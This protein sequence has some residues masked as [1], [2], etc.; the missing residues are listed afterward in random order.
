MFPQLPNSDISDK[1]RIKIRYG[2]QVASRPNKGKPT[3]T[4]LIF[5]RIQTNQ[6]FHSS[7]WKSS[8]WIAS[9]NFLNIFEP[10][11]ENTFQLPISGDP[12][13]YRGQQ[14][15]ILESKP[16]RR[17]PKLI[18]ASLDRLNVP[19][20]SLRRQFNYIRTAEGLRNAARRNHN[21]HW[22]LRSRNWL[23]I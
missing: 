18:R 12:A 20:F 21:C 22:Q 2:Q 17:A 1:Y 13:N 3:S 10:M 14:P 5:H 6:S 4:Q 11:K 7:F 8:K 16:L 9:L 15:S 23:F 19:A